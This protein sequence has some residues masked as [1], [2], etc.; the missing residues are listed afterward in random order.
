MTSKLK[1]LLLG[2]VVI[3]AALSQFNLQAAREQDR[4]RFRGGRSESVKPL[5][6]VTTLPD[7]A[8]L[9]KIIG[10]D[11]ITVESIV[12]SVQ[13][14]HH[15]RPK[16]SF[17]NMVMHA[18]MVISTGL[19]LEMWLPTV[20]DKS[21]NRRVRSGEI[22]YVAVA[23]GLELLEVPEVL[24]QAEGD[25]HIYG[26]PHIMCSPIN[27]RHVAGNIAT[28]LIKND[29]E[30]KKLFEANLKQLQDEID[31][32]LFG[33]ELVKLLGGATLCKLAREHKLIDFLK[34]NNLEGKPLIDRL[35]GWMKTMMPL[36]GMPVVVYH[37]DW[38]YLLDLFGLEEA[39]DAEPKPGIPP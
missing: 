15:I 28:G 30:G 27:A 7:Y 10:G 33:E 23:Q 25:V 34:A 36:R 14:P 13:D 6:V 26:N 2:S 1:R 39:G 37:K 31:R 38:S 22:G 29:P 20:I 9:A 5:R 16:P 12:H 18:D 3:L 8:A 24:S 35:G 11:R 32:R 19:D 4:T 17:V 21:G